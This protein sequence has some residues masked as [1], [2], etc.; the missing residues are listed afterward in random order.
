MAEEG[1]NTGVEGGSEPACRAASGLELRGGEGGEGGAELARAPLLTVQ[2][3][4]GRGPVTGAV[5][6]GTGRPLELEPGGE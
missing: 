4:P 3:A 6:S 1:L 5:R 2:G